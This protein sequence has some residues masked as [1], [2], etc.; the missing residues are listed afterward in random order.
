MSPGARL[1][2]VAFAVVALACSPDPVANDA[3]PDQDLGFE[4][5]TF[6]GDTFA[7]AEHRGT[8]VVINFWE[9]W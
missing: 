1:A 6:A 4:V 8:P 2:L 9:S 3:S 5:E 7:L